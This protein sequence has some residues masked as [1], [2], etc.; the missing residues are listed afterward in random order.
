[1]ISL[2]FY[3]F[4]HFQTCKI[5]P[6]VLLLLFILPL[7]IS[8]VCD[9]YNPDVLHPGR[10]GEGGGVSFGVALKGGLGMGVCHQCIKP[11]LTKKCVCQ[12]LSHR[13]NRKSQKS[14]T[15]NCS[16]KKTEEVIY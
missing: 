15:L 14:H 16:S 2:Y 8:F 13:N 12:V 6:V 1:M 5:W 11:A 7:L 4:F 3:L 9:Q 10:S